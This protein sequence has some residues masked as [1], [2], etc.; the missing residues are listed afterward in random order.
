MKNF[1]HSFVEICKCDISLGCSKIIRCWHDGRRDF[2]DI[3][4]RRKIDQEAFN[5]K[6]S[7]DRNGFNKQDMKS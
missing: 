3:F 5:R 6:S 4:E 2:D 1:F 7:R